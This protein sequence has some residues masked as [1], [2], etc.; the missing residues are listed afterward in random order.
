MLQHG[1]LNSHHLLSPLHQVYAF[2]SLPVFSDLPGLRNLASLG[3]KNMNY[4]AIYGGDSLAV[5]NLGF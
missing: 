1:G 2:S 5:A 4:A 3:S